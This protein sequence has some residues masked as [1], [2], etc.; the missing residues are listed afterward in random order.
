MDDNNDISVEELKALIE[1]GE[2]FH[3]Y[4]VRNPDEYEEANL[5]AKLIPLGDL[6]SR[7]DELEPIKGEHIYIHCRS[8]ARSGRAKQYLEM[9]GFEN[10]HNVLGG[11]LAYQ[12][13]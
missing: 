11:I 2:S 9:E 7:I 1:S 3:F 8:G 4:D 13:L 12:E 10:V 5:G 6:Q